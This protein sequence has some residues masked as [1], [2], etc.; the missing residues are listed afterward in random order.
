MKK[1]IILGKTTSSY[2]GVPTDFI[3]IFCSAQIKERFIFVGI[4]TMTVPY[5]RDLRSFCRAGK[6]KGRNP[7]V[8]ALKQTNGCQSHGSEIIEV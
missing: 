8:L 1:I 2:F 3:I 5:A 6:T 4:K 7:N